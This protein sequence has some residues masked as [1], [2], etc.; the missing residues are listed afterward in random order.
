MKQLLISILLLLSCI[1]INAQSGDD[2]I[3]V[4]DNQKKKIELEIKILTDS[5][6]K[7]DLKITQLRAEKL[8]TSK[9]VESKS[10]NGFSTKSTTYRSSL[11]TNKSSNSSYKASSYSRSKSYYRGPRGGCYYI[12]SKG[13]KSYVSRSLCN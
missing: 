7:I 8:T 1:I 9:E 4:L 3:A 12:N 11:N 6:S 5:I 13:N 2:K 10:N